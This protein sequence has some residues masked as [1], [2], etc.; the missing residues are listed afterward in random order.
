M[1]CH[2]NEDDHRIHFW[3]DLA[4]PPLLDQFSFVVLMKL[5]FQGKEVSVGSFKDNG[6]LCAAIDIRFPLARWFDAKEHCRSK[7]SPDGSVDPD[8]VGAL[9]HADPLHRDA[10]KLLARAEEVHN[11]N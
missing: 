1:E 2:L 8:Y 11:P 9:K 7:L 3:I 4:S 10:K 6:R 5:K